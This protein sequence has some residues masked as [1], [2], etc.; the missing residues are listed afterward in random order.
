MQG[1]GGPWTPC[2]TR[3][4]DSVTTRR[5]SKNPDPPL[6]NNDLNPELNRHR[7]AY[8]GP[9]MHGMI[10]KPCQ[11]SVGGNVLPAEGH[12]SRD[13]NKRV[14][15]PCEVIEEWRHPDGYQQL[16]VRRC[17]TKWVDVLEIPKSSSLPKRGKCYGEIILIVLYI[18][19]P[20]GT[21][22]GRIDGESHVIP[23][24]VVEGTSLIVLTRVLTAVWPVMAQFLRKRSGL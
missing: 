21:N 6:Q 3:T 24:G 23:A 5:C 20:S 11:I 10:C 4:L 7:K 12:L 2:T 19:R 15:T 14:C 8:E 22:F 13:V 9:E 1:H 18:Q 17:F 16:Y